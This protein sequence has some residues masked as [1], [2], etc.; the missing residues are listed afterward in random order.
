MSTAGKYTIEFVGQL[1]SVAPH[2]VDFVLDIHKVYAERVKGSFSPDAASDYDYFG[3]QEMEFQIA[4]GSYYDH[5][6]DVSGELTK[7]Q[8]ESLDM[9]YQQKIEDKLWDLVEAE[10]ED[11]REWDDYPVNHGEELYS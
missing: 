2:E 11:T 1:D 9:L 6:S 10:N 8:W 4:G 3:Y 5:K 7:E